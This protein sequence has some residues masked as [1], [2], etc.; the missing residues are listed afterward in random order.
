MQRINL[1]ALLPILESHGVFTR[2]EI[3][4]L[5]DEHHSLIERMNFLLQYI[6]KKGQSVADEF[7]Q[8]LR[9]EA[10]HWGHQEILQILEKG[11]S[12]RPEMSPVLEILEDQVEV[13]ERYLNL[14]SFLNLITTTGVFQARNLLD[15][16]D[17]Y[18]T[19]RENVS[20][21]VRLVQN[22]GV[23][24]LISFLKCLQEDHQSASHQRLARILLEEGS[25][26]IARSFVPRLL[27][28]HLFSALLRKMLRQGSLGMRPS[29]TL[30]MSLLIDGIRI[31]Y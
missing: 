25:D 22:Q 3:A 9:E 31:S 15:I 12:D 7:M 6:F 1:P 10:S 13:I 23:K 27:R 11:A 28:T 18:R 26:V 4:R 17:P 29:C 14:N 24:G 30:C 16:N 21:L 5:K 8:C 20:R 19:P 2:E